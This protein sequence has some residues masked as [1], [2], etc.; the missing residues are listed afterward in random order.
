CWYTDRG[1]LGESMTPQP[2]EVGFESAQPEPLPVSAA[3]AA[4]SSFSNAE[5]PWCMFVVGMCCGVDWDIWCFARRR[6]I[7]QW[8]HDE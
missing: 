3:D 6:K 5:N 2:T 8:T 4:E 1:W 7:N